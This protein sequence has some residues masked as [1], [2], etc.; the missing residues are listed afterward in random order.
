MVQVWGLDKKVWHFINFILLILSFA[1]LVGAMD[2]D[3]WF[4]QY[5]LIGTAKSKLEG[6]LIQPLDKSD[7]YKKYYDDC[8]NSY[9]GSGFCD[10][11]EAFYNAGVVYILFDTLASVIVV[12]IAVMIIFDFFKISLLKSYLTL[13]KSS[14]LLFI[15]CVLHFLAFVIWAGVVK[16]SFTKCTY[17]YPIHERHSVCGYGGAAFALWNVFFFVIFSVYYYMLVRKITMEEME[18]ESI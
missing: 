16:L 3:H 2:Y 5:I 11:L 7:T 4:S 8:K 17:D 10:E 14:I 9:Y 12:L 13:K 18:H 15:V 1:F 6:G